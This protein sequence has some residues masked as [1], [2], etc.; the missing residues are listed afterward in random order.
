MKQARVS[1]EAEEIYASM[2]DRLSELWKKLT[3][4]NYNAATQFAFDI[5]FVMDIDHCLEKLKIKRTMV[6]LEGVDEVESKDI[7]PLM[8]S[9]K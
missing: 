6:N 2:Q 7:G 9:V 3:T 4:N 8:D 5:G 1:K